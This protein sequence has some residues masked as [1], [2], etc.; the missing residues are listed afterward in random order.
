MAKKK[1][2]ERIPLEALA[3]Q[4]KLCHQESSCL[5]R[6]PNRRI[7]KIAKVCDIDLQVRMVS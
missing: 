1:Q 5:R 6:H 7:S 4:S 2:L 3:G